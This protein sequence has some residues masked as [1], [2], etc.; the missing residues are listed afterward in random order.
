MKN[1]SSSAKHP[2]AEQLVYEAARELGWLIPTTE[3]EVAATEATKVDDIGLPEALKNP[4]ASLDEGAKRAA[5]RSRPIAM[6]NADSVEALA[7]AARDGQ[8]DISPEMEAVMK[9]DR[10]N[11][12]AASPSTKK[13]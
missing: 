5:R 12:E 7:R 3:R 10:E 2:L 11:A 6:P 9:R 4:F 8:G 1:T 13:E